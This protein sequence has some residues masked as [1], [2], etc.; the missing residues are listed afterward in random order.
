M[1]YTNRYYK[2]IKIKSNWIHC[3]KGDLIVNIS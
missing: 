1:Y 2:I 3:A